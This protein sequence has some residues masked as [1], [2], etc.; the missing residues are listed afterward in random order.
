MQ[1]YGFLLDGHSNPERGLAQRKRL[2]NLR[3]QQHGTGNILHLAGECAKLVD[4]KRVVYQANV[5]AATQSADCTRR[6]INFGDQ[7][8]TLGHDGGQQLARRDRV[9][10]VNFHGRKPAGNGRRQND[11]LSG[12]L[13]GDLLLQLRPLGLQCR[14]PAVH[15]DR[16]PLAAFF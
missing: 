3:R 1:S 16:Q 11:P 5:L 6:H 10:F 7:L 4:R 14:D 12:P 13:Q 9:T 15:F 8:Q 2:R